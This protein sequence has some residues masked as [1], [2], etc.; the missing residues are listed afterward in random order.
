LAQ[1]AE[2]EEFLSGSGALEP[3]DEWAEEALLDA[4]IT[5]VVEFGCP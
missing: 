1:P 3:R 2:F 5:T 4:L